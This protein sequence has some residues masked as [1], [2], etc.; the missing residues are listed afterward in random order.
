MCSDRPNEGEFVLFSNVWAVLPLSWHFGC[1]PAVAG[2]VDDVLLIEY[3]AFS[4][5]D[6]LD[7]LKY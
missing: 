2:A 6:N 5:S 4:L 7:L 1:V 3:I